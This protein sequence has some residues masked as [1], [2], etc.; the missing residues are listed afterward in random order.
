[1]QGSASVG[2][3][4][5][6]TVKSIQADQCVGY[7]PSLGPGKKEVRIVTYLQLI[8]RN[9]H[10]TNYSCGRAAVIIIYVCSLTDVSKQT[11]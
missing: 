6:L 4:E 8:Y 10:V 1:M 3:G 5:Y 2:I 11:R 9:L 7:W